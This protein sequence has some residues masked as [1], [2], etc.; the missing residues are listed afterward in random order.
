[1]LRW[2]ANTLKINMPITD[3][4]RPLPD[5]TTLISTTDLKG[6]ITTINAD[7]IAISG[8]SEEELLGANHNI[9]RH[10]HMPSSIFDNMWHTIR[11]GGPWN[12]L[13]INRCRNGDYY[14]VDTFIALLRNR[15]EVVGYQAV[16]TRPNAERARRTQL[17]YEQMRNGKGPCPITPLPQER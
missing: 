16:H 3:Q 5:G 6:I 12:G 14:W 8:Y 9:L 1:M 15:G 17:M 13:V 2:G 4:E 7:L 10:P 11:R